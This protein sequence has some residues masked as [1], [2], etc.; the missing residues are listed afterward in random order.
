MTDWCVLSHPTSTT[1]NHNLEL[2][3]ETPRTRISLN[4]IKLLVCLLASSV[5]LFAQAS[6][7]TAEQR[8]DA[9][10][11]QMTLDE[12]IGQLNQAGG[13][14]LPGA[15]P[16]DEQVRKGMAGSVLWVSEPERS[17]GN[18]G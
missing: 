7:T 13:F 3:H 10:L 1:G 2:N 11:K 12:K 6:K 18:R 17:C 15:P 5:S 9:L 16:A 14:P 8:A 4:L